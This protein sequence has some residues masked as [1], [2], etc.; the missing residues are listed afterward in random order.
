MNYDHELK[1][2]PEYFEAVSEGKK[3]F[4]IRSTSDRKF[5]EGQKIKL[6]EWDNEAES[7]TGKWI[8]IIVTYVLEVSVR[9]PSNTCVFS[10]VRIR[11]G[12]DEQNVE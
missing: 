2:W 11:R 6:R 4:E 3:K 9:L 7:Y 1:I 10:F 5:E 12:N 8:D